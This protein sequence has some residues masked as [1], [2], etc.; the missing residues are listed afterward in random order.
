[1]ETCPNCGAEIR[2]TARFCTSCGYRIPERSI[3][4]PVEPTSASSAWGVPVSPEVPAPAETIGA[5]EAVAEPVVWEASVPPAPESPQESNVQ[6]GLAVVE[7]TEEVAV[8]VSPIAGIVAEETINDTTENKVNIALF[9]IE[10]LQQLVP[11]ITGWSEEQAKAVNKAIDSLESALKGRESDG[12]SFEALRENVKAAKRQSRN[13]DVM[14]ALTDRAAE[15]EDL[16]DAHDQYS[17]GVREALI[18]IKPAAVNYV[19]E[20]KRKSHTRRRAAP[21]KTTTTPEPA[22][23]SVE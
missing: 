12:E 8:P 19:A 4:N 14:V 10:R 7:K 6:A 15:I 2:P 21:R 11:D 3:Q 1:M 13:I 18:S 16:L 5:T 22:P 17:R 9:H 20:V 23:P